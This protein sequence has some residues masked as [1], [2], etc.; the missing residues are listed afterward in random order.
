MNML[1]T[2]A[3]T[4]L[5]GLMLSLTIKGPLFHFEQNKAG[6]VTPTATSTPTPTAT[7]YIEEC[8]WNAVGLSA[9]PLRNARKGKST[10]QDRSIRYPI[11]RV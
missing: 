7:P 6:A 9:P 8:G 4:V 10:L 11:R 2:F 1:K 5:F 3:L